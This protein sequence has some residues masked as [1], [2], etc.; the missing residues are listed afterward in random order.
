MNLMTLP[1]AR[2]FSALAHRPR[3]DLA[4][5]KQ[6]LW[7]RHALAL[8][9]ACALACPLAMRPSERLHLLQRCWSARDVACSRSSCRS[10]ESISLYYKARCFRKFAAP[11]A[12]KGEAAALI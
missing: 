9:A 5:L 4:A 11:P 8:H 2:D 10:I 12:E 1:D 6:R 3:E 7:P